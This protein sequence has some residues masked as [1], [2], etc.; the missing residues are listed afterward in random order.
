MSVSGVFLDV[1]SNTWSDTKK[2]RLTQ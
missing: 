1:E 2:T